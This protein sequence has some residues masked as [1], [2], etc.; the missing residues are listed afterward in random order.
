E[1]VSAGCREIT[2]Y[3]EGELTAADFGLRRLILP[4]DRALHEQALGNAIAKSGSYE[5]S[6]RIQP[7]SG[8][9][10]WLWERGIAVPSASGEEAVLEGFLSDVTERVQAEE[11]LRL[12]K[13]AAEQATLLKD[14]FVSLVAHDLRVPLTTCSLTF[15]MLWEELAPK[16]DTRHEELFKTLSNSA[17]SMLRMID[18]L[19]M[20][21][22]LQSGM[23]RPKPRFFSGATVRSTLVAMEPLAQQKQIRIQFE[24]PDDFRAFADPD[25]LGEVLQ[26]LASNAIKF[27][28]AGGT[29]AVSGTNGNSPSIVIRDTGV[30]MDTT[31]LRKVLSQDD[32]GSTLGTAGEKGTGLGIRICRDILAAHQGELTLES[33][34]GTGTTATVRLPEVRPRIAVFG[35]APG[36]QALVHRTLASY[37]A[38]IDVLGETQDVA[39]AVQRLRPHMLIAG[40]GNRGEHLAAIAAVKAGGSDTTPTMVLASMD[41]KTTGPEAPEDVI[42]LPVSEADLRAH[43]RRFL[44]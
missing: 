42:R 30:G 22:R 34:P 10:K 5:L 26:N 38:D 21:S 32:Y 15:Q 14:K 37:G 33:T 36:E 16:L 44:G 6:Y 8:A 19:L 13:T 11:Q 43:L 35:L 39:G 12:A 25:L 17:Q 2:G 7:R 3:S 18:D 40:S 41:V 4:E 1:F 9:P 20:V 28:K 23:L 29:V 24:L 31:R 27:T